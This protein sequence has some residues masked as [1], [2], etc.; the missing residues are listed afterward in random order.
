MKRD[1]PK[2][3]ALILWFSVIATLIFLIWGIASFNEAEKFFGITL[4][5]FL[6]MFVYFQFFFDPVKV[7]ISFGD[8]RKN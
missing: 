2:I 6:G 3:G 5:L 7:D 4:V 8:S 1:W